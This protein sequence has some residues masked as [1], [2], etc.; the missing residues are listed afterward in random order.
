M[1][2]SIKEISEATGFS[3]ATVSN[4]LNHKRGVS[5]ETAAIILKTAEEMGYRSGNGKEPK[6][7]KFV[8]FRRDGSIINDSHFHPIVIE[9]VEK[10]ARERGI[11]TIFYNLDYDAPD[12]Y[13]QVQALMA[14]TSSAV[15]LLATEMKEEDF[16]PFTKHKCPLIL[17]DGWSDLQDFDSVLINNQDSARKAVNYLI[18]CGH[19]RIGYIRGTN[20]IKNFQ[21]REEGYLIAMRRHN[22]EVNPKYI[23]TVGTEIETAY[24]DMLARLDRDQD[25]PTAFFVDNDRISFGVMRALTERGFKIPDDISII[26]F[27]N[28]Q[29]SQASSPPLTTMHVYKKEM[30]QAAVTR[31]LQ[32]IA[33]GESEGKLKMASCTTLIERKSVK[34]LSERA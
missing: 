13:S 21:D 34:R 32:M 30:G 19:K 25:L 16:A 20:R 2:I 23:I 14:D 1:A 26:G 31:L 12:Y 7:I 3:P 27:D 4:A 33:E 15:I 6:K 11:E 9:G 29:F 17:L 18:E 10:A 8:L 28:L 5:K 22:L 24:R